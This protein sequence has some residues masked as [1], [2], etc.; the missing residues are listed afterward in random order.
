VGTW[1][2]PEVIKRLLTRPATWAVVGLSANTE[3]IAYSIGQYLRDRLGLRIVSVK[4]SWW[5]RRGRAGISP[6]R[7]MSLARFRSWTGL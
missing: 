4:S 3:R 7:L 1:C 6:G 2:D 5:G